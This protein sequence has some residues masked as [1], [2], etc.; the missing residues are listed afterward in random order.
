MLSD[1]ILTIGKFCICTDTTKYTKQH[2]IARKKIAG[3][4]GNVFVSAAKLTKL[5]IKAVCHKNFVFFR[6]FSC[7]FMVKFLCIFQE[8]LLL[9]FSK[10]FSVR[11]GARFL[12]LI[13]NFEP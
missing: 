2:E 9:P 5:R 7:H 12:I 10:F 1:F 6:V 3:N 4:L 13:L 11:I 8:N